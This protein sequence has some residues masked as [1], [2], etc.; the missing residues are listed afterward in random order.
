MADVPQNR[1]RDKK[2]GRFQ[3]LF[4]GRFSIAQAQRLLEH[5]QWDLNETVSFVFEAEP[6]RITEVSQSE[7]EGWQVVLNNRVWRELARQREI[8]GIET[9]QFA[10]GPCD[11]VWWR[12]VPGRK[13]VS[14]CFRCRVRYE[15]VPKDKEWGI[16]EYV[17]DQCNN[18]FK[19]FGQMNNSCS[20]C[21]NCGNRV[22]PARI[23]PPTM[24]S[25]WHRGRHTHSCF[26]H[27]CFN[28]A[29]GEILPGI[30]VHPRSLP[31]KVV[32]PCNPHI[33]SGSTVDTFLTQDDLASMISGS[34]RPNLSDIDED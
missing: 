28:R 26:A 13:L 16:A 24:R 5:H 7:N 27:N 14:K 34:S 8:P 33:S 21:Y 29:Q 18:V 9:R 20:P 17:C 30:C 19:G 31:R 11:K 3:E 25:T 4:R 32:T 10:C 6:R 23:F 12:R 22:Q 15:A 1:D 2:I